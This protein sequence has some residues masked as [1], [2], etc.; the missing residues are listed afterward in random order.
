MRFDAEISGFDWDPAKAAENFNRHRVSFE[1][2]Q[3]AVED[4]VESGRIRRGTSKA[5]EIRWI[6]VGQASGSSRTLQVVFTMR[7]PI[8]RIITARRHQR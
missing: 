1:E 5:G 4:A 8:A 3:G 7:G 2:A 6:A